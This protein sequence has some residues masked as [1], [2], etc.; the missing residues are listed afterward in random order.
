[1]SKSSVEAGTGQGRA[2]LCDEIINKLIAEL[3]A[4][5]VPWVKP[6]GAASAKA[7]IHYQ[8]CL[9]GSFLLGRASLGSMT[10]RSHSA[11]PA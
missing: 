7:V 2:N 4:G 11:N 1:M 3:E 6:W 5:R 8:K 10:A 9:N